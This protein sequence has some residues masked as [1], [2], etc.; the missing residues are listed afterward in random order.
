MD[1][2]LMTFNSK[3]LMNIFNLELVKELNLLQE[4][5]LFQEKDILLNQRFLQM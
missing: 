4:E 3:K 5:K 1:Q 2:L